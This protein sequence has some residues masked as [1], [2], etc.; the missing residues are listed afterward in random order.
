MGM[1]D[2]IADLLTRI[3]NAMTAKHEV[4]EVPT[5][6]VKER[7]LALLKEEGFIRDYSLLPTEPRGTLRV[8]LRYFDDYKSAILGLQRVSKP[9]RR[10]YC[11]A[12]EIPKV[13][14]G[15]GVGVISTSRGLMT[16]RAARAANIGG[17][18]V[19]AVW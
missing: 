8:E 4:C 15:L 17:E 18:F 12:S 13:R 5:S 2:P 10:L 19:C 16:D 9:G 3:R 1:T 6:K 14:N 11:G 7:L